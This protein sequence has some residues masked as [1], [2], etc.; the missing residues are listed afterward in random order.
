MVRRLSLLLSTIKKL[1][2]NNK[3]LGT[4]ALAGAPFMFIGVYL[5]SI[6][7]SL[8]DTWFTGVWGILYITGWMCS[9][10]V[11]QRIEAV[12]KGRFGKGLI[13]V[14]LFTLTVANVSNVVQLFTVPNKPPYFFY[15]D[16][17]WPLSN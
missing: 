12:G 16:L 13:R 6:I 14:I 8:N 9:M 2:M 11:L 10:I 5:E 17:F 3:L 1:F 7:K 4:L 15:I